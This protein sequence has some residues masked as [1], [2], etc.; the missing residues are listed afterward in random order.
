MPEPSPVSCVDG[1]CRPIHP[2]LAGHL[3]HDQRPPGRFFFGVLPSH[4][5]ELRSLADGLQAGDAFA[6]LAHVRLVDGNAG[7]GGGKLYLKLLDLAFNCSLNAFLDTI[8][9]P[10]R[11]GT[12]VSGAL[13]LACRSALDAVNKPVVRPRE[14][15]DEGHAGSLSVALS[16]FPE[17]IACDEAGHHTANDNGSDAE[18][19]DPTEDSRLG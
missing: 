2:H 3:F 5:R 4:F 10:R 14:A 17:P 12:N 19:E 6:D 9:H 1:V 8:Q 13:P 7:H 16:L 18:A 15:V 11:G